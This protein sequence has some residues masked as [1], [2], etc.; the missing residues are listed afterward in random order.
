MMR[1]KKICKKNNS[2]RDSGIVDRCF[3][4]ANDRNEESGSNV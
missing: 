1:H 3:L 2:C 4:Y